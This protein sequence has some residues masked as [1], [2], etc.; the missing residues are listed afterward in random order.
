MQTDADGLRDE[1]LNMTGNF[2]RAIS[3]MSLSEGCGE[4]QRPRDGIEREHERRHRDRLRHIVIEASP[5]LYGCKK[6]K[7]TCFQKYRLLEINILNDNH[8]LH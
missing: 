1:E 5:A 4:P 6:K 2:R 7:L 8:V 3:V